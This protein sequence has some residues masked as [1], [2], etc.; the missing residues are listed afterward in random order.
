MILIFEFFAEYVS[1][2]EKEVIWESFEKECVFSE[3]CYCFNYSRLVLN[4]STIWERILKSSHNQ[5]LFF[6][7]ET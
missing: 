6:F 1:T 3:T 4:Y 5:L 2:V 7:S